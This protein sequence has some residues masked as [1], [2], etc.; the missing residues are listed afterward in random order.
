MI[1]SP[2]ENKKRFTDQLD[3]R[4]RRQIS[5]AAMGLFPQ[6]SI[7]L[8]GVLAAPTAR[9]Y[10]YYGGGG[11]DSCTSCPTACQE[12]NDKKEQSGEGEICYE[13]DYTDEGWGGWPAWCRTGCN[14][15]ECARQQGNC[16]LEDALWTC[17]EGAA[18]A[19]TTTRSRASELLPLLLSAC[20]RLL[21][22]HTERRPLPDRLFCA[23]PIKRSSR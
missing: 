5:C 17:K 4:A 1:E 10:Y 19:H 21:T 23:Q 3:R 13:S 12:A 7:L 6:R 11:G 15:A 16:N 18:L 9:G 2:N 22:T 20:A 8:I 14:S